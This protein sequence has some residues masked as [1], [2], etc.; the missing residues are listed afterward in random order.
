MEEQCIGKGSFGGQQLT[1]SIFS[2]CISHLRTIKMMSFRNIKSFIKCEKQ[3][4]IV[5]QISFL[6]CRLL[7]IGLYF[8]IKCRHGYQKSCS[9]CSRRQAHTSCAEGH[10]LSLEQAE[11][12]ILNQKYLV[13]EKERSVH[14][15]VGF[16]CDITN[17]AQVKNVDALVGI[18]E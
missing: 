10:Y 3:G 16:V 5:Y 2:R 18:K 12:G 13:L 1:S 8:P 15:M 11:S 14:R 7:Y 6:C 9:C 4:D 17:Y